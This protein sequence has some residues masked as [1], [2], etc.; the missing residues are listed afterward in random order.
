MGCVFDLACGVGAMT[1]IIKRAE[2]ALATARADAFEKTLDAANSYLT[3]QYGNSALAN[4][5]DRERIAKMLTL[6]TKGG[7]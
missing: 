3:I 6:I 2:A 1:D 4:P 5:V 7:T